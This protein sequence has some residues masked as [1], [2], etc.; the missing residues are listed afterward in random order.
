LLGIGSAVYLG[1][2]S[3]GTH[4]RERERERERENNIFGLEGFQAVLASP[5]LR[6]KAYDQN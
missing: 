3:R 5:S 1:S 2:E 4:E 6:G